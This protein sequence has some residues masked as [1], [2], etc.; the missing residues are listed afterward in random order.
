MGKTLDL[1]EIFHQECTSR[2]LPSTC[3]GIMA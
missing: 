1:K 2:D 3:T